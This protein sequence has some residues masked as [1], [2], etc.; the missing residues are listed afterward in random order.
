M[1][2][3]AS[4]P[5][6]LKTT[7]MREPLQGSP[8]TQRFPKAAR[9]GE[10][11]GMDVGSGGPGGSLGGDRLLDAGGNGETSELDAARSVAAGGL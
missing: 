9:T 1:A 3:A 2:D 6:A 5:S 4:R 7:T 8:V 10:E 11:V